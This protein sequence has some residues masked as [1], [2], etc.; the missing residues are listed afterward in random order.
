MLRVAVLL[1]CAS[2]PSFCQ[3]PLP[4]GQS[5][6]DQTAILQRAI[7]GLPPAGVLDCQGASYLVTALYLKS[8]MV[9]RNCHLAAFPG[10]VD[11]AAPVT[12]DGRG[13]PVSDILIQNVHVTGNR[14][15]QT[16]IGYAGQEDG[17]RHCFRI[18]GW[19][20]NLVI[21]SSS[22]SYCAS[23]GIAFVSYGVSSSDS[24][25]PFRHITVRN[26]AFSFNRR[27]GVSADGLNDAT[28]DNV[29]FSDNGTT[30]QG[31]REGDRCASSA[32][33]CYGTGF[34]YEDYQAGAAGEGLS[35]IVFARCIFRNNFQRSMFFYTRSR[36]SATGY[37]PRGKI[38]IVNSYLDAGVMP[39]AEDYALQFQVDDGL[40]GSGALFQDITIQNT[41][42]DGSLGLHQAANVSVISSIIT[43]RLPWLGYAADSTNITLQ[44]IQPPGKQLYASLDPYGQ[45]N[46]VVTY[47]PVQASAQP[48]AL[49][50]PDLQLFRDELFYK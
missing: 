13:H 47:I 24:D 44:S 9:I 26:S 4:A 33:Q 6:V 14:H 35:N 12:I 29:S 30:L 11:F 23:D 5:P 20:A 3:L 42:M 40:I 50:F 21:E 36:P 49:S 15:D 43:T 46:P 45:S 32:G 16:N 1:A 17:G 27:Q 19:V 37:Q 41:S 7:D 28:F 39:L 22:G 38:R 18:L 48:P 2:A 10:A 25:L 8:D 34:W 31:G